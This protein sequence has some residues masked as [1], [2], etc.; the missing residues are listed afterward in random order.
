MI[1]PRL[2]YPYPDRSLECEQAME[3]FFL[4]LISLAEE[5]GW[6]PEESA[7]AVTS[8]ADNFVLKRFANDEAR[9][10]LGQ[11]KLRRL[12]AA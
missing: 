3:D 7:V 8:L 12:R 2:P 6:M 5:A 4:V 11:A 1:G 9:R 10:K